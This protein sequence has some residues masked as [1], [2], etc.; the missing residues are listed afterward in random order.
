MYLFMC[1]LHVYHNVH[2]KVRGLESVLSCT[3]SQALSQ[4]VRLC[5]EPLPPE[6]FLQIKFHSFNLLFIFTI[7]VVIFSKSLKYKE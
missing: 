1:E 6:P 7:K 5:D 2:V 4:V 3:Q